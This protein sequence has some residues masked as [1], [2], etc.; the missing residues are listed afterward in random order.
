MKREGDLRLELVI[1]SLMQKLHCVNVF[2][3]HSFGSLPHEAEKL[4]VT[5]I[6][7]ISCVTSIIPSIASKTVIPTL[8]Y[9]NLTRFFKRKS[10]IDYKV[11]L[12]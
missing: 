7:D 2:V 10:G 4:L 1:N 5:I 6:S 3:R 8:D 12:S 11:S 9:Q